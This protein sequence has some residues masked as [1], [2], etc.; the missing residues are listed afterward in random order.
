MKRLTAREIVRE[1][2]EVD[3]TPLKIKIRDL[4]STNDDSRIEYVPDLFIDVGWGDKTCRFVS[5]IKT[6]AAPKLISIAVS[7][8]EHFS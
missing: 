2:R 1:L 5:E 7:Q 3:I 4:V 8:F 6:V